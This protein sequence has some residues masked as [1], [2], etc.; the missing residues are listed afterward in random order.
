MKKWI[1]WVAAGLALCLLV[2]GTFVI[3]ELT[4]NPNVGL[5]LA[6]S[7]QGEAI[8]QALEEAELVVNSGEVTME[9]VQLLSESCAVIFAQLSAPDQATAL[10]QKAGDVPVVFLGCRPEDENMP[11]IG[12]DSA[13]AGQALGQLL[14]AQPNR[15]DW[16]EDGTVTCLLVGAQ[17]SRSD[18]AQWAVAITGALGGA[19]LEVDF[20]EIPGLAFA[21]QTGKAV[22]S[23]ALA[24][25]GKDLEAVLVCSDGALYGAMEALEEGGRIPGRNVTLLGAGH[26]SQVAAMV[27]AGSLN[28]Y[29]YIEEAS[30]CQAV[31]D[32][33]LCAQRGK[34]LETVIL[35]YTQVLAQ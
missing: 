33:A 7:S 19:G 9:Q 31:V 21:R 29:A 18:M 11:Y 13:Q 30:F 15:G 16:N 22:C 14:L 28:G 8:T 5:C 23:E 25:Y 26:S 1:L 34:T 27:Q 20:V 10:A 4:K 32:A 24:S 17:I 2:V 6:D 12:G 35:E 3:M